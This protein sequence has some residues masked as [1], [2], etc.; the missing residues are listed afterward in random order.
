MSNIVLGDDS[1]CGIKKKVLHASRKELEDYPDGTRVRWR[2]PL[3]GGEECEG[4]EYRV[5][6]KREN[7][8]ISV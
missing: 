5:W 4:A 2:L 3:N 8:K 6:V 1:T 7:A